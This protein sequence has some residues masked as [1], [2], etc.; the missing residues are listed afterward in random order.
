MKS[1]PAAA[2]RR[3]SAV[4]A[5]L[6]ALAV[7]I[8]AAPVPAG[9]QLRALSETGTPV[10]AG[11][12][13]LWGERAGDALRV[14]SAPVAGGE[15]ALFGSLPL[16]AGDDFRIAAG[17]GRVA[18][19]VRDVRGFSALG[20]L[21]VAGLDG[22]FGLAAA[23][24]GEEPVEFRAVSFVQATAHGVLTLE[25]APV[26][27][28]GGVRRR[29]TLPPDADPEL[30]AT[31]G[32]LGVAAARGVLIV[33]NLRSGTEIRQ[34]GLDR[35][36]DETLNGLSLSPEGD[37]AATVPVGDGS[38]VLLYSPSW[39][40]GVRV[41]ATGAQFEGVATAGG[42][43]AFV[44]GSASRDGVRVSV[45]SGDGAVVY[46]GPWVSDATG[47]AFDGRSLAFRTGGCGY[48][49]PVGAWE[50]RLPAGPCGR[51]EVTVDA[52]IESRR[53]TARVTCI[54]A[55]D[56]L[57]R[58]SAVARTFRGA[59]AGR[60]TARVRRGGARD[61]RIRLNARG[62]KAAPEGLQLTVRATDPDGRAR[63]VYG[64]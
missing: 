7:L 48:A 50:A 8:C 2:E 14:L 54:N 9:A 31:A 15:P 60:A 58:V 17:E 20:R 34:I 62:R 35:F 13:V 26:L 33:F 53:L 40:D 10:L 52:Q 36:E 1:R 5:C 18:A 47:L 22:A 64:E 30:I 4:A 25:R 43:V 32:D 3:R 24:I 37:V 29:V 57:C 49:G 55:A 27:R 38:D 63:V 44:G 51:S 28:S 12:R 11:D 41:L 19:V 56:D 16:A 39:D 42:R 6:L 45:L 59:L 21:Y 23:D 61:L 46:R